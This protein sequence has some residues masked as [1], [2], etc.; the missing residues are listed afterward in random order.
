MLLRPRP[1]L[2]VF[3]FQFSG[4]RFQFSSFKFQV[5]GFSFQVSSFRFQIHAQL[6]QEASANFRTLDQ[7]ALARIE[8]SFQIQDAFRG[9][10]PAPGVVFRAPAE[11]ILALRPSPVHAG[12]VDARTSNIEH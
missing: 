4:F 5:S 1:H 10:T 8:M 6:E 2:S 9:S 3:S 12:P 11:N 7:E